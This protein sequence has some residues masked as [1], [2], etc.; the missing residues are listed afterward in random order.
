M[1]QP[2]KLSPLL[3]QENLLW[4]GRQDT[5]HPWANDNSNGNQDA[6]DD[7]T[8]FEEVGVVRAIG[9]WRDHLSSLI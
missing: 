3:R 2:P 9:P 7:Q 4:V 8:E 5:A 6:T 1:G